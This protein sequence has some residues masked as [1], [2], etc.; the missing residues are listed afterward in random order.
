M[1]SF[2]DSLKAHSTHNNVSVMAWTSS[3]SQRVCLLLRAAEG[4]NT[5]GDQSHLVQEA[6]VEWN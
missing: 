5:K 1:D 6:A 2:N 3:L 4:R